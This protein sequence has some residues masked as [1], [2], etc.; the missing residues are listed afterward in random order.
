MSKSV[1][2]RCAGCSEET[3]VGS[4]FH[5]DRRVIDAADGSRTYLCSDCLARA[6]GG[7]RGEPLTDEEL[8]DLA[9]SAGIGGVNLLGGFG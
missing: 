8:R 6:A 2:Q 9:A 7:R 3:S 5:S 1:E 4:V